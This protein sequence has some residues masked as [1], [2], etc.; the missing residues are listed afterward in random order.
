VLK[1][2]RVVTVTDPAF[3]LIAKDPDKIPPLTSAELTP[4]R[5]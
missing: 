2:F 1:S 3:E 5:V 4:L